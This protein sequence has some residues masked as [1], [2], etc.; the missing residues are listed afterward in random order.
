MTQDSTIRW[1]LFKK[2][3]KGFKVKKNCTVDELKAYLAEIE[4][5][6]NIDTTESFILDG[7]YSSLQVIEGVSALTQDWDFTGLANILKNNLQF[8]HLAKQ[9]LVKYGS[10]SKVSPEYQCLFIVVT[11]AYVCKMKNSHQKKLLRQQQQ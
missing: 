9:L 5:I 8:N 4:V 11:S 2:E 6:I 3:L 1:T 10:F 7:I